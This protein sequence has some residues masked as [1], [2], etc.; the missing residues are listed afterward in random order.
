MSPFL[1]AFAI[2]AHR[3]EEKS[4][5]IIAV[6]CECEI[7][8]DTTALLAVYGKT[9]FLAALTHEPSAES[10]PVHMEVADFEVGDL[11]DET[12]LAVQ[13]SKIARSRAPAPNCQ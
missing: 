6:F 12:Q 3:P 4:L 9:P 11:H 7:V 5:D 10:N 2:V 1:K 8:A 13:P